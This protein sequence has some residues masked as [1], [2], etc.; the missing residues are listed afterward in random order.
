MGLGTTAACSCG[1]TENFFIGGGIKNHTTT[2]LFPAYCAEEDRIVTVNLYHTPLN[3]P[4]DHKIQPVSYANNSPLMHPD[5]RDRLLL[6]KLYKVSK[7]K[8]FYLTNGKYFC[9]SCHQYTLKF[10]QSPML[11][12]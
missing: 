5:D 2:N 12:D 4:T 6:N 7:W 11:W 1:Y 3:C 10:R 8:E 9:P